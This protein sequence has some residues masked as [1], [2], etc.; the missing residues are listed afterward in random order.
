LRNNASEVTKRPFA[1]DR[2]NQTRAKFQRAQCFL[3]PQQVSVGS[4]SRADQVVDTL[5]GHGDQSYAD[6]LRNEDRFLLDRPRQCQLVENA[7]H[8]LTGA[9]PMEM[10][11]KLQR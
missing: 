2:P 3:Q 8:G 4:M 7:L 11:L 1:C 9:A 10:D 6:E 5:N